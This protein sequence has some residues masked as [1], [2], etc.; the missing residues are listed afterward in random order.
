[1]CTQASE[2][3]DNDILRSPVLYEAAGSWYG[4]RWISASITGMT[5]Q[6]SCAPGSLHTGPWWI[7]H[8]LLPPLL[9]HSV[10]DLLPV[11]G[12]TG[13][14]QGERREAYHSVFKI[15]CSICT[16]KNQEYSLPRLLE[17]C[18]QHLVHWF[19]FLQSAKTGEW[20]GHL[21]PT[22]PI[23]PSHIP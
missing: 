3:G 16:L 12:P 20:C 7:V 11:C 21:K 6:Y 9:H 5:A 19:I 15:F 10:I 18:Y 2:N 1:M 22:S 8:V 17:H 4:G 23:Y 13:Q 14:Q